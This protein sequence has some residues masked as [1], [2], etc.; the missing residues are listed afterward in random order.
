MCYPYQNKLR[1]L[2]A[3]ERLRVRGTRAFVGHTY[4]ASP[5]LLILLVRLRRIH[6]RFNRAKLTYYPMSTVVDCRIHY[7]SVRR[8][9]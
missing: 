5:Y 6:L 8:F 4:S 9:G 1:C 7:T 3:A 2:L